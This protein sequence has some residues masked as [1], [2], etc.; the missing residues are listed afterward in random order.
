[1][2]E[3]DEQITKL[4]ILC[5]RSSLSTTVSPLDSPETIASQIIN[6]IAEIKLHRYG[7]SA[8]CY[9]VA[10]PLS[11]RIK[12][13]RFCAFS[14][15]PIFRKRHCDLQPECCGVESAESAIP[16]PPEDIPLPSI[17]KSDLPDLTFPFS[18]LASSKLCLQSA[19]NIVTLVD[20]LPYPNPD[21]TVPLTL[22]PY[23]SNASRVEIP[24]T[25]PTFACCVMQASYALL[26]LYLKARSKHAN[27]PEDLGSTKGLSLRGFL[28]ELQQNLRLVAK[29]LANY[30]I[31]AEA[32][33]G[34]KGEFSVVLCY[35]A[36]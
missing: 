15:V 26:M 19:L 8:F 36:C 18:S 1:M 5:R 10:D 20:N 27:S 24:R 31:A 28:D 21:H 9:A 13:H 29:I 17:M 22:P 25:M 3:L 11:A 16:S 23:L 14:D 2:T 4:T 33:Q 32:L 35:I 12:V 34:M 30:A 6:Q 7:H